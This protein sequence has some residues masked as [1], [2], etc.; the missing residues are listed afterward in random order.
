MTRRQEAL[1]TEAWERLNA[2]VVIEGWYPDV[3]IDAPP[4]F[5]VHIPGE[6]S[7]I[8]QYDPPCDRIWLRIHDELT[9][10]IKKHFGDF[11]CLK[12]EKIR[13]DQSELPIIRYWCDDSNVVYP[14][15]EGSLGIS[16]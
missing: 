12:A 14:D 2:Y 11:D 1:H 4:W 10:I 9:E 13:A 5:S 3:G 16:Y 8:G 15:D 7:F 6:D